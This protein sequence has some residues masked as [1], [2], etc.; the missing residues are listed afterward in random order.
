MPQIIAFTSDYWEALNS[1]HYIVVT[2]HFIDSDWLLSKRI[3]GF[4]KILFLIMVLILVRPLWKFLEILDLNL[5][6]FL[7]SVDNASNDTVAIELLKNYFRPVLNGKL[8]HIRC[9]CHIINLCVQDGLKCIDTYI[10][11]LR[12]TILFIKSSDPRR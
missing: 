12:N 6:L 4:K 2:A 1:F 10:Q 5:N 7:I 8:F 9:V 3:I 11:N